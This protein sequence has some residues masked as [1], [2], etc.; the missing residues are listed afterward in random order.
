MLMS[1]AAPFTLAGQLFKNLLVMSEAK[2]GPVQTDKC[3]SLLPSEEQPQAPFPERG[4]KCI[5]STSVPHCVVMSQM[6]NYVHCLLCFM[7]H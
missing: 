1:L 3:E 7:F 2:R 4:V 5:T 6:Q